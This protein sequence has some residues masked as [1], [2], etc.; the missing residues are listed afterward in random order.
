MTNLAWKVL[1]LKS[2]HWLTKIGGNGGFRC[3]LSKKVLFLFDS[4]ENN[5]IKRL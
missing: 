3:F 5:E 2:W 4:S 1:G